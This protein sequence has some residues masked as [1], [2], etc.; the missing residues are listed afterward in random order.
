MG[1]L[2]D[3]LPGHEGFALH[4]RE[5]TSWVAACS[6]GWRDDRSHPDGE[7]G[8]ETALDRWDALHA[9]PLLERAVPR[10]VVE[11][12]GEA[13]RAVA[14]LARRRPRA[15]ATALDGISRWCAALRR[16]AGIQTEALT[17]QERL[18]ALVDRARAN[19]RRLG[20]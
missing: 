18:D 6:C 17:V 11:L 7:A 5:D 15:A 8:Y 19:D 4:E 16:T 2:Y 12:V 13:Q 3:D 14:E 9:G 1:A 20:R 10:D